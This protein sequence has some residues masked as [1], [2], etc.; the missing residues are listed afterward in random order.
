MF[1]FEYK[2]KEI[3]LKP[4]DSLI[5]LIGYVTSFVDLAFLPISNPIY[6]FQIQTKKLKL[7]KL[8]KL[9]AQ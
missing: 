1:L 5:Q 9:K 2:I 8:I 6:S 7:P 3:D 4:V